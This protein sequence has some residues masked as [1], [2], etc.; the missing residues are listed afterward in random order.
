MNTAR[1]ILKGVAMNTT[2]PKTLTP[3]AAAVVAACAFGLPSQAL[4]ASL[5]ISQVPLYL[6]GTVE[7]NILFVLDDSGSMD[8]SFMPD[9]IYS[10]HNTKRAKSSYYNKIYY[11]PTATYLPPLD[12][13]GVSRGDST[14]T[15]AWKDGYSSSRGANTVNL[16]TS[17]RPTW[18]YAGY[19][20]EYSAS[21][22][23][24]FYY[25]FNAGN[26]NCNGTATDD[27]CYTYV[28]VGS[29]EETNFA[30][31]YS[32]YRDRMSAAK[33]GVSRAFAQ[34]GTGLRIGY[35]RINRSSIN[36]DGLSTSTIERGVRDFSDKDTFGNVTNNRKQFFDWLF[37]QQ[38]TGSTPLRRALDAAGDYYEWQDSR[39]AASTTPG[40]S[41]GKDLSCRQNFTILTTDG[42]WTN[43]SY[44]EAA[45]SGARQNNDGS[46]GPLIT[47]PNSATYQYTPI[48]PFKDNWSNNLA[49]IAMYYWNRDLRSDLNNNVPVSTDDP[50]FWQHMVTFG[51]GLGV[52]GTISSTTA[53]AA[54]ATKTDPGWPSPTSSDPAKIDDLLHAS[55][56]GRGEFFSA[57]D[58]QTFA[59]AL[60][61]TLAT[62]NARTSS[63]ATVAANSTRL[64]TNTLLFQARF[65]SGTWTG[66]MLAYKIDVNT[67]DPDTTPTWQASKQ[68][69]AFLT[70]SL[71]TINPSNGQGIPLAW[72][73]LAT[74][75]K[76]ALS[77]DSTLLEWVR[78][79]QSK[80]ASNNGPFRTRKSIM[81]DVV[82]SDPAFVKNEDYG[83]SLAGSLSTSERN[84]YITRRVSTNFLN[85]KGA[86]FFGAN[87]G[88]FRGLDSDTGAELFGYVPNTIMS[89]LPTLADPK[90]THRYYVD[91]APKVGDALVG[92]N[93][94]T[95]LVGSTGAG[96]KGYF[97]LN[98]ENAH[99][100]GASDV[101]WEVNDTTTGF[102]ELGFALGQASIGRTESGDW[103]AIFGNG[104]NSTA[105]KAQLFVVNISTGA[106]I[107][108]IDTSVGSATTPNG[109]ATPVV[110]D[111][112][113]NGS[114][115]LV[116]AGDLH[117]NL[118]K[119]DFTGSSSSNWKVAFGGKPLFKATD[120]GSPAQAQPITAKVQV[121]KHPKQGLMV[122]FG[123]GKY[124]ESGDNTD[125]SKQSLY[126]VQDECGIGVSGTG[127]GS[128]SNASKVARSDLLV[129]SITYEG[130][131]A[132]NGNV[133]EIRQFSQNTPTVNQRG[134][135]VDL[136]PPTN[137][138]AGERILTDPILW[139]DR[140][141][142]VSSIPDD[143]ACAGGGSSWIIE[144][145]PYTG[146]RTE[147]NVFDLA[148]DGTYGSSNEY[149]NKVVSGRR[150]VGGM[151]KSLGQVR[152]A[153]G[154]T[155]K[156]GSTSTG[157]IDKSTQ[158]S[159]GS[160]RISW[161]QLQ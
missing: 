59:N 142:Y 1:A 66:D 116:Y 38:P 15:S 132:F 87:D 50:A 3:I 44:Y 126:G 91:G 150:V 11:D 12:Q 128:V 93:W 47:G 78:G 7:P 98:V 86:L 118:W 4:S 33:A 140:I 58:P 19:S 57:K 127:C 22:Q 89:G 32:Y 84:A 161:R 42:Y 76:T 24:A 10:Y 75:Q 31:W 124:F 105:Q 103:V 158:Q 69:P 134:F 147:H 18:Y 149:N 129:Q 49:D 48:G 14:F 62:I 85:R 77:N 55:L 108:K 72:A 154:K 94:K 141:I 133:W 136:V 6:G 36:V 151:I 156:Y 115:D 139:K 146:A 35:G 79:D 88:I 45:T 17:F 97:A 99:S 9:G 117:G 29:S 73:S 109:L 30:N 100:F 65:D 90:Y 46:N 145:A 120:G 80:E 92:S 74:S 52:E 26:A 123:T 60:A 119:F 23:A 54:I 159:D 131:Q 40:V 13:D 81:G 143:D 152:D 70:R 82:N 25:V 111:S 153:G 39:G 41:G 95:V 61:A 106:L 125:L 144:L 121:S 148:R 37:A 96:G 27:D 28:K 122:Y 110:I 113:Q 2:P 137:I 63:A 138:K 5:A 104:Y 68:I 135:L 53:F 107:K 64:S 114:I 83:Y 102:G 71:F 20:N 112:D 160:R 130:S 34:Q 155:H 21:S 16:S 56:N 101:L 67:G 8:W 157:T 51:V 43:G